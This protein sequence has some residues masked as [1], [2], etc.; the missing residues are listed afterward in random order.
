[1]SDKVWEGVDMG[2]RIEMI[3]PSKTTIEIIKTVLEQHSI[4]LK[5]NADLLKDLRNPRV[6]YVPLDDEKFAKEKL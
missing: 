4:I 5:T 6:V 2:G 3:G 1:M